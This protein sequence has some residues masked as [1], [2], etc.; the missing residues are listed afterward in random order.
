MI[1]VS[2]KCIFAKLSCKSCTFVRC[3]IGLGFAVRLLYLCG[4]TV[5]LKVI[6]KSFKSYGLFDI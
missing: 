4:L 6:L 2:C 1:C 5:P 3:H